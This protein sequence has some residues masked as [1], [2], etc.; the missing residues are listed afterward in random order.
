MS[1][2][3]AT[4]AAAILPH[5]QCLL[6]NTNNVWLSWKVTHMHHGFACHMQVIHELHIV[7]NATCTTFLVLVVY[8]S[9]KKQSADVFICWS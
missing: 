7:Q 1:V 9:Q 4:H 8:Y 3:V 6:D 5:R 2:R